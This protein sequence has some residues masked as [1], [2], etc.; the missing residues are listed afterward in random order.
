MR[1][2]AYKAS[3]YDDHDLY[4]QSYL[5][6]W[7]SISLVWSYEK[8]IPMHT[9][10]LIMFD[11]WAVCIFI[12]DYIW[13][14]LIVLSWCNYLFLAWSFTIYI[15]YKW[16]KIVNKYINFIFYY[17]HN[18]MTVKSIRHK[19]YGTSW[20][21]SFF[22]LGGTFPFSMLF[23]AGFLLFGQLKGTSIRAEAS[24]SS[25]LLRGNGS[26]FGLGNFYFYFFEILAYIP[27]HRPKLHMWLPI[28]LL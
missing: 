13:V 16:L 2:L 7:N 21:S 11:H 15:A 26:C 18:I 22:D 12:H 3:R 24:L 19:N 27:H 5:S 8:V 9:M 23:F 25:G 1:W 20:L 10:R 6:I 14:I 17:V 28:Y 4:T